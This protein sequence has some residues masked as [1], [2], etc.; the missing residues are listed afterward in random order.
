ML[1]LS[2]QEK[3]VVVV[4]K[5]WFIMARMVAVLIILLIV[6]PVILTIL[7]AA[8]AKLN[9]AFVEH[10]VNFFLSLYLMVLLLVFFLFWMDHHLDMWI[11]TTERLIDVEQHG[12]FHREVSEVPLRKIQDV[13]IQINGLIETLLKF[14]TIRIQTAGERDFFIH[15]VPRL[16]EIKDILLRY[17]RNGNGDGNEQRGV[18]PMVT[19]EMKKIL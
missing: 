2:E 5:H 1:Q 9:A 16:Y 6:P 14:G 11:V 7:P 8:T 3:V 10:I 13:T 15:N 4:R 18:P 17:A 12:L 19:S